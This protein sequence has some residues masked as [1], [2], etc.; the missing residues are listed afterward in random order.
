LGAA[1]DELAAAPNDAAA[2]AEDFSPL[3]VG[4]EKMDVGAADPGSLFVAGGA[5]KP[6]APEAAGVLV[7]LLLLMFVSIPLKDTCFPPDP[8]LLPAQQQ[9]QHG[10]GCI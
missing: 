7:L 5:P 10:G 6:K 8:E 2:G 9:E 4:A 1:P 3:L